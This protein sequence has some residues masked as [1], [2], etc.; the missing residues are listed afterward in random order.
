[1][2]EIR[3]VIGEENFKFCSASIVANHFLELMK[4]KGKKVNRMQLL[5]GVNLMMYV[6]GCDQVSYGFLRKFE[7]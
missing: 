4:C 1:M 6:L 3:E 2:K 5:A 7:I